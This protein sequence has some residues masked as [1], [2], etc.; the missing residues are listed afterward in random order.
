MGGIIEFED[1][2][3]LAAGAVGE[4]GRRTFLVQAQTEDGDRITVLVEKQQVATLADELQ[5]FLARLADEVP[6]HPD[7]MLVPTRPAVV[8]EDVPAFRAFSMAIGWL[9]DR[10]RILIELHEHPP[11]ELGE[12]QVVDPDG[13]VLRIFATRGAV[14]AMAEA[15]VVAVGQGRPPCPLCEFPMDPDGHVC[16]RWN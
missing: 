9:P 13:H 7:E 14:R 10:R 16:P 3:W 15:A 4:P 6:P 12:E 1:P 5:G 8:T 2:E 11:L